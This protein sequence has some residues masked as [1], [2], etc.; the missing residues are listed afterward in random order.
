MLRIQNRPVRSHMR[1]IQEPSAAK[2]VVLLNRSI[3]LSIDPDNSTALSS[4]TPPAL[5]SSPNID[6]RNLTSRPS[7]WDLHQLRNGTCDP[8][9]G[10]SV[11]SNL[12]LCLDL[13][14][15]SDKRPGYTIRGPV[16]CSVE[17]IRQQD[18]VGVFV[19][20]NVPLCGW[21]QPHP[22]DTSKLLPTMVAGWV[23]FPRLP[24]LW[25]P[26]RQIR[27]PRNL[28]SHVPSVTHHDP[29]RHPLDCGSLGR[30]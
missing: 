21:N 19:H 7:G 8:R 2:P 1:H 16:W 27:Q 13:L 17:W 9:I 22:V 28:T 3:T 23:S 6:N 14:L 5:A 11:R 25:R 4:E 20:S 30:P 26:K 15:D 10:G 24:T 12:A 18:V 29:Y